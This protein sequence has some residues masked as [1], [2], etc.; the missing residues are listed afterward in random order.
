MASRV[1]PH[2]AYYDFGAR[3]HIRSVP[4]IRSDSRS[5]YWTHLHISQVVANREKMPSTAL[6]HVH[7]QSTPVSDSRKHRS[8]TSSYS[9]LS[10]L[11]VTSVVLFENCV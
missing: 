6:H 7:P 11:R 2:A 3:V 10:L 1:F 9:P 8:C 4:S 5:I